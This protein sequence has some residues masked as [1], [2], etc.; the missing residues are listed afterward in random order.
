MMILSKSNI[1]MWALLSLWYNFCF[2]NTLPNSGT[3]TEMKKSDFKKEKLNSKNNRSHPDEEVED[4][5]KSIK[6]EEN[7][8]KD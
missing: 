8:V 3:L 5:D 7:Q 6:E 1:N 4:E 2:K